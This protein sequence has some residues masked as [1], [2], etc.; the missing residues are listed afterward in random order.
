MN[1]APKPC[2]FCGASPAYTDNRDD[3]A[4]RRYGPRWVH[5]GNGCYLHGEIVCIDDIEGWNKRAEPDAPGA[6]T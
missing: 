3:Y 5:P 2:P 1:Q 6:P 4:V